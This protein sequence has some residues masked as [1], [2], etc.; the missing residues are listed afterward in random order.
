[1]DPLVTGESAA[2]EHRHVILLIEG[3]FLTRWRAGEY[4]RET[5]FDVIEA[6]SAEES[7]AAI[8]TRSR[9]DAIFC[10]A[11]VFQ[12]E[13]GEGLLAFLESHHPNLPI[14]LASA[15]ARAVATWAPRETRASIDKPYDLDEI[16]RRLHELIDGP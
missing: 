10:D 5:G 11:E 16:E 15:G 7:L 13:Q 14:L 6:V 2:Q 12:G 9:I 4:L 8:Q 1:M 3:D